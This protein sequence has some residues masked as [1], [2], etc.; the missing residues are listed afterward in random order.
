[1]VH[2]SPAL[3][4]QTHA[5]VW[6][7][8]SLAS[9]LEEVLGSGYAALDRELPGGGWPVGGLVEILQSQNGLSAWSLLLPAL[10]RARSGPVVLVAPP[11]TPFGPGLS[12]QGLDPQRLLWI[13]AAEPPSRLWASE[14]ALRCK[15]V[16]AVLA[17]L[18]QARPE[19]LRRLQLAAS[20]HHKLL[21]VVRPE[22]A[23]T[24][25]SPAVLRVL[26]SLPAGDEGLSLEILKRRGPPPS[27]PLHLATRRG[28]LAALLARRQ[29][30][31]VLPLVHRSRNR[32][33][34]AAVPSAPDHALDR[35]ASA[36]RA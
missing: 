18:N 2:L 29:P 3:L 21:F 17:W 15:D 7:A 22:Q 35:I 26:A 13:T 33:P 36:A 8:D 32:V 34:P 14:Q 4:A 12:A 24:E 28:R 30:V 5:A 1:M 25:S 16:V 19:Q 23:R 31:A 20:D 9:P 11:L 6:R 10:A 27:R